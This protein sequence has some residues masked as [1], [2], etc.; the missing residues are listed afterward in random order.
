MKTDWRHQ[1][2]VMKLGEGC[3]FSEAA[4]AAG[5]SRIAV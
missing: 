4:T 3:T 5:V 1:V 2:V